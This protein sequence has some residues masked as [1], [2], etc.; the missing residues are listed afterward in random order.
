MRF[1]LKHKLDDVFLKSFLTEVLRPLGGLSL[2]DASSVAPVNSEEPE[3]FIEV[4]VASLARMVVANKAAWHGIANESAEI[5]DRVLLIR[6]Y[7]AQAAINDERINAHLTQ[8]ERRA[9]DIPEKLVLPPLSTK[10]GTMP[11]NLSELLT[12]RLERLQQNG[13]YDGVRLEVR[14]CS[15]PLVVFINS[16]WFCRV[17]DILLDNAMRAVRSLTPPDPTRCAVT[18]SLTLSESIVEL[19]VADCGLGIAPHIINDL[20]KGKIESVNGSGDGLWIAQAIVE[21]YGGE[22]KVGKTDSTGTEMLI[23]L[24]QYP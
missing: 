13:R 11:V 4:D 6:E 7:L 12:E 23:R 22:I 9:K 18:V 19:C 2:T 15:Q 10:E 14:L 17:L 1:S 24:P 21:T 5:A 3:G 8:V 16:E 20:F